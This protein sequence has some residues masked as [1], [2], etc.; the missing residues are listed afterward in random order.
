LHVDVLKMEGRDCRRDGSDKSN[1]TGVD[2]SPA[3]RRNGRLAL[4]P[5]RSGDHDPITLA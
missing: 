5:E 4:R 1:V 2:V 3:R